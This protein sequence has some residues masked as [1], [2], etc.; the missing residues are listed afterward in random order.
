MNILG[1]DGPELLQHANPLG[2]TWAQ[3]S[4]AAKCL[5]RQYLTYAKATNMSYCCYARLEQN[6][7][8]FEKFSSFLYCCLNTLKTV[9]PPAKLNTVETFFSRS[10]Y[11]E[12]SSGFKSQWSRISR[13]SSAFVTTWDNVFSKGGF[14]QLAFFSSFFHRNSPSWTRNQKTNIAAFLLSLSLPQQVCTPNLKSNLPCTT[15]S[16]WDTN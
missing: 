14:F 9:S 16:H 6:S 4:T 2:L 7:V 11:T 3:L 12:T 10:K 13:A 1:Q 15:W 8:P 5:Q